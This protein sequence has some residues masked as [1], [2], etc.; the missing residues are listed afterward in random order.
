M[1]TIKVKMWIYTCKETI[2]KPR[3]CLEFVIRAQ[4]RTKCLPTIHFGDVTW[5]RPLD[6]AR[7]T[8]FVETEMRST[9]SMNQENS[10]K[11]HWKA[12]QKVPVLQEGHHF[13]RVHP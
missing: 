2:N 7:M 5:V 6:E 13:L 10:I 3:R 8:G 9:G 11:E 1:V 12:S 4:S